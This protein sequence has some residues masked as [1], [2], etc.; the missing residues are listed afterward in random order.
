MGR[1]KDGSVGGCDSWA[2]VGWS[3]AGTVLDIDGT[4]VMCSSAGVGDCVIRR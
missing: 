2:Y 1:W 3:D 4:D